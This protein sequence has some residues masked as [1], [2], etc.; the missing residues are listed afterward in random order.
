LATPYKA[1]GL[2]HLHIV[3]GPSP[4]STVE[5]TLAL[6]PDA[7]TP[8]KLLIIVD[9]S[10]QQDA[11][12]QSLRERYPWPVSHWPVYT[13]YGLVRWVLEARW[14]VVEQTIAKAYP[15]YPH[16]VSLHPELVGLEDT[17][18]LYRILLGEYRANTP[19]ALTSLPI[20]DTALLRQLV[21]RLRLRSEQCLSIA[22]MNAMDALLEIP[23]LTAIHTLE[24]W[25]ADATLRLRQLDFTRQIDI[26]L[27]LVQAEPNV[28]PAASLHPETLVWLGADEAS[29][30]LQHT[31][32]CLSPHIKTAI[33][34]WD[35][36]GG[37]RRGYLNA[38]PHGTEALLSEWEASAKHVQHHTAQPHDKAFLPERLWAHVLGKTFAS[39]ET[40]DDADAMMMLPVVEVFPP[41]RT[42]LQSWEALG[43]WLMQGYGQGTLLPGDVVIVLPEVSALTLAP[44]LTI[45]R[46]LQLP[47]QVLSG[48][49]RPAD[50]LQGKMLLLLLQCLN[51]HR[52]Q[53]PLSRFEWRTLATTCMQ[54]Q[55]G[56]AQRLDAFSDF[57]ASYAQQAVREGKMGAAILP[58]VQNIPHELL[59]HAASRLRYAQFRDWLN[60]AYDAPLLDQILALTH[61]WIYPRLE[62]GESDVALRLLQRSLQRHTRMTSLLGLE[63]D[64][65]TAQWFWQAKYGQ[66]ADTADAPQHLEASSLLIATPQ[67][68]IDLNLSRPH[69]VWLDAQSPRWAKTDEAPLYNSV[70]HSPQ[71][72]TLL[73]HVAN[74]QEDD[75]PLDMVRLVE[76]ERRTR[77]AHGLR[78]LA[79]LATESI[80]VFSAELDVEGRDQTHDALL[81]RALVEGI[82]TAVAP[83][84]PER[85][86]RATLREDQLAVLNYQGGTLAI[87]AVPGAGKTFVIVELLLH[88][89]QQGIPPESLLVLTYMESAART[90]MNRVKPK[91][92][93]AGFLRMPH[94]ST[95]HALAFRILSEGDHAR[96]IGLDVESFRMVDA[97]EQDLLQKQAALETHRL[98][99]HS[100][101]LTLEKWQR[102]LAQAINH[103]KALE[104]GWAHL[105]E[106]AVA[107][108]NPRLHAIAQGM[109]HYETLLQQ[110]GALDFTDLIV[111]A[112]QLLEE[113]PDV[114]ATYQQRFHTIIEDE[115]QDSSRL[116]QRLLQLLSHT[117]AGFDS[118]NLIRC[119]DTNQ[120]ITTTFSAA[121]PEV[122]RQFMQ[123]ADAHVQMTHSGRCAEAVM[124][125]ANT[126]MDVCGNT[127]ALANAF[128]PMHMHG[129]TGVNP[130]LLRPIEA[131]AYATEAEERS[132]LVASLQQVRHHH[133]MASCAVLLR[134]NR[135]V[136]ELTDV[137]LNE[138]LPALSMTERL[139]DIAL[140]RLLLAW[141]ECLVSP[142]A[143]EG[144]VALLHT[145]QEREAYGLDEVEDDTFTEWR[146]MMASIP[147]FALPPQEVESLPPVFQHIYEEWHRHN[148][149]IARQDVA[150]ALLEV[151]QPYIH[152]TLDGCNAL[153]MAMQARKILQRYGLGLQPVEA[154]QLSLLA[155]QESLSPI[156]VVLRHF[157]ELAR[158]PRNLQLFT[159]DLLNGSDSS[160]QN[161][162]QEAMP[163]QVMTLH[164]SKGME[165]DF[166]WMP[167][168]TKHAHPD[169]LEAIKVHESEKALIGLNR[170]AH[171]KH[172]PQVPLVPLPEALQ[173]YQRGCIEEEARLLYVGFS[174]AK[175][176]LWCG[177]HHQFRNRF[178]K[179][180][181]TAP[182]LAFNVIRSVNHST[183][184]E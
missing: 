105:N 102:I 27:K 3:E 93:G 108:K 41:Q 46:T 63:S 174:R 124:H 179:Q 158:T 31:L 35:S 145:L 10:A 97:T 100:E 123:E 9:G 18:A 126:W 177:T 160:Q 150:S 33:V 69:Y 165:F 163:I 50:T 119:G 76:Q 52:W 116:L 45:L 166:V 83:P 181:E 167:G 55:E 74:T 94:I 109:R 149:A 107:L 13:F 24:R 32:R 164:K 118:P 60:D 28:L 86:E 53:W 146:D 6:L 29:P 66:V 139:P 70:V 180:T 91:L 22:E 75:A 85:I 80:R 99:I 30:A 73:A 112:V 12:L 142:S 4:F 65:R 122:F 47:V 130:S 56:E 62:A 110:R 77:A 120:S 157:R 137:L 36:H 115:A 136:L 184:N 143:P 140:F 103:A 26:F 81:Y 117:E 113:H 114:R 153:L 161:T 127:P 171:R 14:P 88:L 121:E 92:A 155:V 58:D 98:A 170:L 135:D 151:V 1:T 68:A 17:E 42:Q 2:E 183:E 131:K 176:G 43:Q 168:L 7:I 87:S 129:L 101:D 71:G 173:A 39:P 133:P 8:D 61:R 172:S 38:Y 40:G 154:K 34:S 178:F 25:Y 132:A 148:Q 11:V 72:R 48:T 169:A 64:S 111:Y 67:K 125:I 152:D 79:Y 104:L 59:R 159:E 138:G 49:Q 162:L 82:Q 89:V 54:L 23:E 182:T 134:Y 78:K 90:L 95:I 5:R 141:L 57:L 15:Q 147:L 84:N 21:R 128:L 175:C 96:R 106:E 144:R 37:A 44:L 20:E 156:E 19:D 16:L 51:G